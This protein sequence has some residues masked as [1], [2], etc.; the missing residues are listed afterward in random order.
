MRELM[1]DFRNSLNR[2]D[3][4][5]YSDLNPTND[6]ILDLLLKQDQ[7]FM[8]DIW[9]GEPINTV[10]A[11]V[12][13]RLNELGKQYLK[14]AT[15]VIRWTA[16]IILYHKRAQRQIKDCTKV[17]LFI[18]PS[19]EDDAGFL[20]VKAEFPTDI[21]PPSLPELLSKDTDVQVVL[22]DT[23][24]KLYCWIASESL[25]YQIFKVVPDQLRVTAIT[26][27]Y[28]RENKILHL[29]EADLLLQV[30]YDV[31]FETFDFE[32]IQYPQQLDKRA[33]HVAF[34][35]QAIYIH[36]SEAFK[37]IGLNGDGFRGYPPFDSTPTMMSGK[38]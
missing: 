14:L 5:N 8:Y 15:S 33:F 28:L 7:C 16:G 25:D 31:S 6:L 12:D 37:V 1:Q 22:V 18:K 9:T 19:Q 29:F 27:Y 23:K 35:Y 11:Q 24:L 4:N 34:F 17:L 10:S 30:A 3:L 21:T 36:F 38:N 26:L 32:N 13:V 20:Q 2:Y